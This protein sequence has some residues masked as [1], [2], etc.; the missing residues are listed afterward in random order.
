MIR[1]LFLIL[2]GIV[3]VYFVALCIYSGLIC[4]LFVG[5]YIRGGGYKTEAKLSVWGGYVYIVGSV[6]LYILIRL[7]V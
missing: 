3:S 2:S 1:D 6:G 5:P 4:I 7:I